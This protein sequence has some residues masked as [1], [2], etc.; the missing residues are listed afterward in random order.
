[1]RPSPYKTRIVVRRP[2]D[3]DDFNGTVVVEWLNVTAGRDSD[4][5]FGFLA[6]ELMGDGYA[7]VAVSAQSTGVEPGGLGMDIPGVPEE[8]MAPLKDWDPERYSSLSHPGDQ[9]S[10][11]IFSQAARTVLEPGD[12]APLGNL[13]VERVIAMGESQSASR[14]TTYVNAIQPLTGMFDGFL[15]HSR[16]SAAAGL[17]DEDGQSPPD[18]TQIREDIDVPVFQFETE[19]DLDFLQFVKARQDDHE[20]LVTWEAAGTAHADR[21]TL[22]YGVEAGRRWTDANVDLS[23]TC[24]QVNEGPQ[25]PD[26]AEGVRLAPHVDLRR[27]PPGR[28][29]ADPDRRRRRDRARRRRHRH[30]RH[31]HAGGRRADRRAHRHQRI[32]RHHLRPVRD[33]HP[34]HRSPTGRALRRPRRLR[35]PR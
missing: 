19:T 23:T 35:R 10:Y 8:A 15:V 27:H 17:N 32:R 34:V 28:E 6:P 3:A 31:P 20:H 7:Y 22:D 29:P 30:R 26:R 9:Y 12:E 21:S 4:P 11:D 14:L 1:M 5:D 25:T 18:G 24:G 13:P 2:A 33:H 16:G